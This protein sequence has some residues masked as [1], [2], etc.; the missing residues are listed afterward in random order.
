MY[1]LY[2]TGMEAPLENPGGIPF[3]LKKGNAYIRV[4]L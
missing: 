3:L 2:I 1:A 4:N